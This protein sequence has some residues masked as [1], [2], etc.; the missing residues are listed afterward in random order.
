MTR[1]ETRE[2]LADA[3]LAPSKGQTMLSHLVEV[4][5]PGSMD[6]RG[7]VLRVYCGRVSPLSIADRYA[8]DP[9]ARPSCRQCRAKFDKLQETSA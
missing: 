2:V 1:Y 4:G 9:S 7:L 8:S 3:Y 5:D 6:E